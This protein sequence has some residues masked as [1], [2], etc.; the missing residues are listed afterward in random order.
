M[1]LNIYEA[2]DDYFNNMML[3]GWCYMYCIKD[4]NNN[5]I[6]KCIGEYKK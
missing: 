3:Y 6:I 4:D 5:I 1:I 2:Y